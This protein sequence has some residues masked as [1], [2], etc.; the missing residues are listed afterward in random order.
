[1][2][3]SCLWLSV[4]CFGR[5]FQGT[6]TFHVGCG[7]KL[8]LYTSVEIHFISGVSY[9]DMNLCQG[10]VDRYVFVGG[11]WGVSLLWEI[12]FSH[13]L[14]IVYVPEEIEREEHSICWWFLSTKEK[15]G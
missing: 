6:N 5:E 11:V 8:E 12:F 7:G 3:G 2:H 9:K 15:S 10:L 4:D 1:M 14:L 13:G